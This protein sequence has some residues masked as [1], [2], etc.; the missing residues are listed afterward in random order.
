[1]KSRV[2]LYLKESGRS[3]KRRCVT[4]TEPRVI[5]L[6]A[7]K[8]EGHGNKESGK[9]LEAEKAMKWILPLRVQEEMWL[10]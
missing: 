9:P 8:V 4:D 1:M 5:Q 3:Q 6:L 10:C 7:F 2:S